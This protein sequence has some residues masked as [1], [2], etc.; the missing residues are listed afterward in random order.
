MKL[1]LEEERLIS[2]L[3]MQEDVEAIYSLLSG[4]RNPI[5][6]LEILPYYAL[7]INEC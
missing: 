6:S 3:I 7:F 5:F 1:T 4:E 2:T